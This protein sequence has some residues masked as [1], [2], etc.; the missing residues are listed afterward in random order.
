MP[1]PCSTA[2]T[3]AWRA[4]ATVPGACGAVAMAA[5]GLEHLQTGL[6]LAQELAHPYTLCFAHAHAAMHYQHRQDVQA[7]H[8][9]AEAAV[10]LAT[11]H[12]LPYWLFLEKLLQGWTGALSG[13]GTADLTALRQRLDRSHATGVGLA[14]PYAL[15]LLATACA[16][17]GAAGEAGT[18]L[19][20]ALEVIQRTGERCY[21][22]EAHRLQGQ[23]LL[24]MARLAP[25][26]GAS[27]QA[28][29]A[30]LQQALSVA[31]LQHAKTLEL[32]AATT[33]ARLWQHQGR[34]QEARTL[35][36]PLY[37]WFTEGFETLDLQA[38]RALLETLG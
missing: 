32:R 31:R 13:A 22:A 18:A 9:H 2:M 26:S 23:L 10:T 12:G 16:H 5:Q 17:C 4:T 25:A 34:Q 1:M 35:L 3:L 30:R 11:Q 33:L 19:A 15:I 7:T 6:A 8:T 27:P 36:A 24:Q 29:E 21:E 20:T 14:L 28:V 37:D 38:A